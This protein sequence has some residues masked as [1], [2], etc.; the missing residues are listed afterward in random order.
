MSTVRWGI[1]STSRHAAKSL[2]P[3]FTA[4]DNADVVAVASRD[5]GRAQAFADAHG[6]PTAHGSYE[7][8]LA[9]PDVD[10]VYIPVPNNLHK[11][12]AIRA[13][14]AGKHVLCEKPIGLT[15]AEAEAIVDAAAT[16]GVKLQEAFQWRHHPQAQTARELLHAGRVGELR[17]IDA[18]F[19]FPL[20]REG[21][22][23]WD[24]ALGGGSLYDVGCYP[25]ALARYMTGAEPTQVTAQA[26]WAASGVDDLLGGTLTFPGGVLATINSG[27]AAPLRRYYEL[28]GSEGTLYVNV[29][30]NPKADRAGAVYVC[31]PDREVLETIEVGALDS[32]TLMVQD[33]SRAVID[34]TDP[35]F[36]GTDA[37]ANMRVIDALYAAARD[38]G[39]VTVG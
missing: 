20:E 16:A 32:Y 4:A 6:I 7:D 35:P 31:G 2:L 18:G 30:Y 28:V 22:V 11:P 39:T 10:A 38:G 26:R 36:P 24:P 1:L 3:A 14:H 29:A 37:I 21:D 12:W 27:F 23:R 8:L 17:F 34:D 19:S 5:Q 25:V 33:F 13:A 15:A 9:A